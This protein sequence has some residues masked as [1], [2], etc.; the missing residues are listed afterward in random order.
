LY[1]LALLFAFSMGLFVACNGSPNPSTRLP[2]GIDAVAGPGLFR[3]VTTETGID[4]TYRNGEESDNF[5]ILE[6]VG[7]GVALLDYDGDGLVDI[8]VT[9]G[10]YFEGKAVRG[11]GCKLYKNLGNFRFRDVTKETGVDRPLFYTHG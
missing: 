10:G 5:A 4:F 2:D 9:G 3:D 11:H 1:P 6:T 7:G 8:F